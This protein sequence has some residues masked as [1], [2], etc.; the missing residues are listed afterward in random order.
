MIP[1]SLTFVDIET[2]GTSVTYNRVIEVGLVRVD[3]GKISKEYSTLVNP[4]M[5]IDPFIEQLTGIS[6]ESLEKAP[7]F[8]DI[9]GSLLEMFK[10]TVFVAHNVRFDYAF[11]RNEFRRFEKNFSLKHFCTVKLARVLYPGYARYNLDAIIERHN[12][13]CEN[14]HRALG[15]AK[16]IYQFFTQSLKK[17]GKKKVAKAIDV[18]FKKPT[19]PL[20]ISEDD[21]DKLPESPGVY[22]FYGENGLPLYIGKS[23]N[24]RDR[25]MSHFSGDYLSSSDMNISQQVKSIEHVET[26]GELGALFLESTLIKRHQ[27]LFNK[28]LR[29][30]SKLLVLKKVV[31]KDGYNSFETVEHENLDINDL[32]NVMSLF[33]SKK[34]IKDFLEGIAKEKK[35][36][37]RL[38]GLEKSKKACFWYQLGQ[39]NGACLG[40]ESAL[41]YNLRFDEAFFKHRIKPWPFEGPIIVTEK[42]EQNEAFIFDKWCFL[43][44]ATSEAFTVGDLSTSYV[45]DFDTYKILHRFLSISSNLKKIKPMSASREFQQQYPIVT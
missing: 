41:K 38:L 11:L 3:D 33:K 28:K 37:P 39:C 35:L 17:L 9:N 7:T 19:V 8:E 30:T 20:G 32:E 1:R 31:N 40:K 22:L 6:K 16:V 18:V 21:L 27:P 15:D 36:C 2:T 23:V 43:G 25:V 34:Q 5:R 29:T 44:S 4:Q 24:I 26:A 45:F 13:V 42:G 10:D 14:R 12:I